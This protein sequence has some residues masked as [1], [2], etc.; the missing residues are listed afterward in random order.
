MT[1]RNRLVRWTLRK[2]TIGAVAIGLALGASA[3]FSPTA[4]H[5]SASDASA[6]IQ[7][8]SAKYSQVWPTNP[9]FAGF[10]GVTGAYCDWVW[11]GNHWVRVVSVYPPAVQ[12]GS[13]A[14]NYVVW[15]RFVN[16]DT[17]AKTGWYQTSGTAFLS[18]NSGSWSLGADFAISDDNGYFGSSPIKAQFYVGIYDPTTNVQTDYRL[19]T[20]T[21][22]SAWINNNGRTN[23]QSC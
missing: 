4:A 6:W 11:K 3:Q 9:S 23:V 21:Q 16:A 17:L 14:A 13:A 19:L 10:R 18:A 2:V 1:L 20:V 7:E 12:A 15:V 5:A 8:T 22:Y